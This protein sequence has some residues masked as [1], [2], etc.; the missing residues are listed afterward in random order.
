MSGG[1][2]QQGPDLK[3]MFS[4]RSITIVGVSNDPGKLSGK[5]FHFL[6]RYGYQ[7]DIY[8][9]NPRYRQIDGVRCYENVA[10]V[11][12]QAD[13]AIIS[14]PAAAVPQALE[15]C[16]EQGIKAA[17]ILS[18]GFAEVGEKG[19]ELEDRIREIATRYRMAICGPNCA[20]FINVT[21]K[22]TASFVQALEY[23]ELY[24][25]PVSFVGQSGALG[26]AIMAVA[27]RDL[28]GF[29]FWVSTGNEAVLTFADYVSFV[30]EQ[31]DTRVV[32]GYM[33]DARNGEALKQAAY[34]ALELGKP[35]A[36]LKA[37]RS[38]MG[39]KAAASHTGALAGSDKVY[40]AVFRQAGIIRA[41]DVEQLLDLAV[42]CSSPRQPEKPRVAVA[43]ISGGAGIV[44]AD[45]CE[46]FGLQL[47]KF[48][49]ETIQALQEILPPFAAINNPVDLTTSLLLYPDLLTRS[50]RAMLVDPG[51]DNLLI[52]LSLQYSKAEELARNIAEV[53]TGS[54][55]PVVVSWM[56]MPREALS[57][58]RDTHIPAFTDPTRAVKAMA[59]LV[60]YN[61]RRELY[62]KLNSKYKVAPTH[63]SNQ[64]A[65]KEIIKNSRI[66]GK[67]V[68]P[69]FAAKQLLRAYDVPVPRGIMVK[70]EDELAQVEDKITFPVVTKV[71]SPD[72]VHKTD[73]GAVILGLDSVVKM[74]E[75]YRRITMRAREYNPDA[76]IQ[77]VLVEEM[78]GSGIEVIIG[79]KQ[80]RRFGPVVTVGLGGVFVEVFKDVSLRP[81]PVTEQEAREMLQELRAYPLLLGI[82]G[83]EPGDINE[84]VK[85]VSRVSHMALDLKNEI[86][87]LDINPLIVY[88]DRYG[89]MAVDAVVILQKESHEGAVPDSYHN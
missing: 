36:I 78:A 86:A 61:R 42:I 22:V 31:E 46:E 48:A 47:A 28:I 75:A 16:A 45:A 74:K 56:G 84:L 5:P 9:V 76:Y 15:E 32:I 39:A 41:H 88:P 51:V 11:P 64:A 25:G 49:P 30:I 24:P 82:R 54:S 12:R 6:Q 73:A 57:I 43:T 72:I 1:G 2:I 59:L 58:L 70:D 81:A 35:V 63:S 44:I 50:M 60:D 71:V 23:G 80:D 13:L 8:L 79:I 20:G 18:S 62:L 10:K 14:L 68:I 19:Q 85:V 69:E 52:F 27:A 38:E 65:A 33:E 34:R 89:V 55:K 53:A 66:S 67:G 17:V 21:E 29:N 3:V 40:D 77:G 37:G 87:E 7:G 26:T 83:S 4:P